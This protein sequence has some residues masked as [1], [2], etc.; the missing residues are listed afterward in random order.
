MEDVE[1]GMRI[2]VAIKF[3]VKSGDKHTSEERTPQAGRMKL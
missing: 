2:K 3:Q 1:D